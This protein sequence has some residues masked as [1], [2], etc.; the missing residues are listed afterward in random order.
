MAMT[1]AV[2]KVLSSNA[3]EIEPMTYLGAGRDL[4]K[5]QVEYKIDILGSA[6]K[7]ELCL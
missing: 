5:K 7:A 1:A 6:G 4:V 2:R 3:T